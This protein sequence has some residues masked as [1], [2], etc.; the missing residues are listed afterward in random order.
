M[1]K[2][3]RKKKESTRSVAPH[4]IVYALAGTGKTTTLVEGLK[5][6]KGLKTSIT[7]SPQQQDIWDALQEGWSKNHSVC[8]VA[9]NR[10]IA[11][12]LKQRVP[13]GCDACTMHSLGRRAIVSSYPSAQLNQDR[14]KDI[15]ASLLGC[16]P[17]KVGWEYPE[18]VGPVLRLVGFAKQ[19]LVDGSD[20]Q[21]LA[22]L[23]SY[24]DV[25]LNGNA[26]R[27]F[28]LVGQVLERCK[29]VD[30][31][32]AFDFNDMIWLPVILNLPVSR[33]DL[34]LVDEAQDLNRCQQALT[35]RAGHRLVYCGDPHQAIYGFAGAD[36]ESMPRIQ[37]EL[38]ATPEG[39]VQLP[40][41]VTRRCGR[42]IV[43][44]AR[45]IVPDFE[46]H[47]SNPDGE[48]LTRKLKGIAGEPLLNYM[49]EV[50]D[51]DM[52]LCRVNAPLVTECFRF[53]RAGQK[54][55]IQGRN[56]GE[57]LTS[58]IKK[59]MKGYTPPSS[60]D[61]DH[62]VEIIELLNR[63]GDWLNRE[64]QKEN[65]KTHP[66]EGRLANLQDRHDCIAA[67]TEDT[68]RVDEVLKKIDEV[69][70]DEKGDGITL[71]SI[72]KA[73]GLESQRVF[74]IVNRDAPLPHP[75]AKSAWAREQE[76]NLEYVAVTRAIQ[77]L[78][79]VS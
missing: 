7:P 70:S 63:L 39:C 66:S 32:W 49:A 10:A 3:F 55:N 17:R 29:E 1:A 24:Y 65:A 54:A 19:N 43:E 58:T 5:Y 33:Y 37:A 56:I 45:K 44:R 79:F 60:A 14:A 12:V 4:V 57:G 28:E 74:L 9:F 25:D 11:D 75:M 67:F 38:G 48:I 78:V 40:L 68:S 41:T 15:L 62:P 46:A 53:L 72:H 20:L 71:S 18:L 6:M 26:N 21:G 47:E 13:N 73:K 50:E 27:V 34:L 22:D 8:F 36:A 16:P 77:T 69:F 51:G 30:R 64:T 52:V 23:A 42:A 35:R 76:R 2:D 31:D 59:L 61:P